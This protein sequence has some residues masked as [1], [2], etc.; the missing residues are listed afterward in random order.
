LAPGH[1]RR[2]IEHGLVLLH[3]TDEARTINLA[4]AFEEILPTAASTINTGAIV[5]QVRLAPLD[6]MLLLRREFSFDRGH[7]NNGSFARSFTNSGQPLRQAF[8]TY[9]GAFPGGADIVKE[10]LNGDGQTEL[11]VA[12]GNHVGVYRPDGSIL[13][14]FYPYGTRYQSTIT[15]AVGDLD[16]NGK[17]E[18]VTGTGNGGGPQV[19]IFSNTGAALGG[20]FAY[21]K[22][23][24]GGVN[25]AVGDVNGDGKAE[26]VTGAGIRGGP[27]VRL[28]TKNGIALGG[29]FAY[30]KR[31]RGGVNVAV[32]DVNG[33]GKAEILTAPG[34][35]RSPFVRILSDHGKSVLH[36]FFAFEQTLR[37]GVKI[38]AVDLNG[39]LIDDILVSTPNIY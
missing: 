17:K 33:D 37:S 36:G 4:D 24:R 12:T 3:S 34:P 31:F 22:R 10:D 15:L 26:I 1:W 28:F 25:V 13:A 14:Q 29:F 38:N 19:R 21:D 32:G 6:G 30:D 27:H 9:D 5:T 16:G 20:F 35:G 8:L 7:Y 18:I 39:D 23:F 2:A 11:V